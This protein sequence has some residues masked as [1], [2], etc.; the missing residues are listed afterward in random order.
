MSPRVGPL[1]SMVMLSLYSKSA[2]QMMRVVLHR[3][4]R[5]V[6]KRSGATT[7]THPPPPSSLSSPLRPQDSEARYKAE[8]FVSDLFSSTKSLIRMFEEQEDLPPKLKYSSSSSPPSPPPAHP[9]DSLS[10]WREPSSY[11][12]TIH[13]ND[14]EWSRFHP[15]YQLAAPADS[16]E[17]L[18]VGYQNGGAE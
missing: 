5:D 16:K 7:S 1:N 6:G 18:H 9:T 3:T 13:P 8:L 17:H 11:A 15:T 2:G 4:I 12:Q 10:D 14:T